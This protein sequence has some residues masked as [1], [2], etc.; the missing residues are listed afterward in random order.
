[1]FVFSPAATLTLNSTILSGNGTDNFASNNS[2]TIN[3]SHSLFGD[4][5]AEING[6]NT[7]NVFNNMPEL[8]GLADNG[9]AAMA[10]AA[11]TAACVQ[12]HKPSTESPAID[13]GAA[14]GQ[15]TDQRG[16]GF[17]RVIGAQ[18]DIGAFE[19]VA[20]APSSPLGECD[21]TAG[22]N[23]QDV[24]CTINKVLNP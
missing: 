15:L 5:V 7:N 24:I 11:A 6:T 17:P 1:V 13:A 16:A 14:N 19:R 21:G 20:V 3:A 12:T 9:C 4:A 22:I 23:I 18:A 2:P 10:G 8:I